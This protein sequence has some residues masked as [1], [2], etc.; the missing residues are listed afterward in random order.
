[1]SKT[2]ADKGVQFLAVNSNCNDTPAQIAGHAQKNHLPFPVLR[3]PANDVADKFGAKRTPEVVVLDSRSRNSLS[4]PHRRPV[5]HRRRQRKP[6][7]APRSWSLPWMKCWPAS[8]FR[9]GPLKSLAA[10]SAALFHLKAEGTITYSRDVSRI[11]QRNCQECHR[12]GQIGPMPLMTYEDA[13]AWSDTVRRSDP[14]KANAAVVGRPHISAHSPTTAACRPRIAP[15][16][17]AGSTRVVPRA[18]L[19]DLP[20]P[21]EF[22]KEGWSIG[23]PDVSVSDAAG[24]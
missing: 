7:T 9:Y 20:P 6:P 21:K 22:P 14:T 1:M 15:P 17:S 13:L 16:Y 24:V 12:P 18:I 2:Y 11:L 19:A 3:D 8:P 5:R 23:K 10:I 4:R